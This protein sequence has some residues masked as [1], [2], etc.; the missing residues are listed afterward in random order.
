MAGSKQELA[1]GKQGNGEDPHPAI[2]QKLV[3]SA[4]SGFGNPNILL[5]VGSSG[6]DL[7]ASVMRRIDARGNTLI[8][9]GIRFPITHRLLIAAVKVDFGSVNTGEDIGGVQ[10]AGICR[11][12]RRGSFRDIDAGPKRTTS[13]AGKYIN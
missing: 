4:M 6:D 13:I 7:I 3:K 1:E 12:G 11:T 10:R 9:A 8:S 2:R 5:A